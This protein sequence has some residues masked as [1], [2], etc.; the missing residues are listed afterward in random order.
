MATVVNRRH[1][2]YSMLVTLFNLGGKVEE[3]KQIYL[4]H[5]LGMPTNQIPQKLSD[6]HPKGRRQRTA[7]KKMKGSSHLT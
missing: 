1:I 2:A 3:Y 6:Y 5:I 4:E 7:T